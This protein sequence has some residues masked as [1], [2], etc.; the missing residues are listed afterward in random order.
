MIIEIECGSLRSLYARE[1]L[2]P[3][4][5]ARVRTL[6]YLLYSGGVEMEEGFRAQIEQILREERLLVACKRFAA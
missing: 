6:Q 5:A 1:E 4:T 3:R 2:P